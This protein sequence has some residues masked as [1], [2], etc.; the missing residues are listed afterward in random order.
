MRI[1]P[2]NRNA[3]WVAVVIAIAIF[4]LLAFAV[5]RDYIAGAIAN[6]PT[7]KNLTTAIRIEPGDARYTLALGRLYQYSVLDAQPQLAMKELTRTVQLN[8]YDARAWLD[9]GT[10]LQFQGNDELAR[11]CMKRVDMLAPRIPRYQWALGNFYLV[12]NNLNEAFSHF[13]M[14]LAAIPTYDNQIFT[15]AWKSSGDAQTILS[16]LIPQDEFVQYRYLDFLI[17]THRLDDAV[18]VWDRMVRSGYR[19][20][21]WQASPYMDALIGAHQSASAYKVWNSL[22]AMGTIP[23]TYAATPENLVENGDFEN[24]VL[25]MGFDWRIWPFAGV[26]AGLDDSTFRSPAKSLMIQ[27][28]GK[29]NVDYHAVYQYVPVEPNHTYRLTAYMKTDGITT[30]SGPRMEVRDAYNPARLDKFTDQVT[31]TTDSWTPLSLTFTTGPKTDLIT[32]NVARLASQE[33]INQI[34]GKFWVDDVS[35]ALQN[36]N[37]P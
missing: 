26:Y 13:Q 28:S 24:P 33:F 31:G 19:V 20:P 34:S 1:T 6:R 2:R 11:A 16:E 37:N 35:L 18:A 32:I 15:T 36:H 10:A 12:H 30:D 7:V 25:G 17:G 14:V 3:R 9:L 23:A 8:P 21:L 27:F 22:R 4:V 5:G 29:Q